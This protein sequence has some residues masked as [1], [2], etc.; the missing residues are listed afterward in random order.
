MEN[1]T[2]FVDNFTNSIILAMTGLFLLIIAWIIVLHL[3]LRRKEK[4]LLKENEARDLEEVLFKQAENMKNLDK[5]IQELYNISNK[6]NSL[7]SRSIHKTGIVRFNP[8]KDIGGDQSFSIA[9]LDG[10]NNGLVISSLHTKEGTRVYTKSISKGKSEKHALTQEE[11]K[12]IQ[13]A[14]SQ[15]SKK[16]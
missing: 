3:K 15:V 8:F 6:I 1:I 10:K 9:F 4:K 5:D 13:K 11:E 12:A 2:T 16:V 14:L 7:A